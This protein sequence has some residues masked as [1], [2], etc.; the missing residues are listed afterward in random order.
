[1]NRLRVAIVGLGTVGQGVVDLL[2]RHAA[3]YERR[4]GRGIDVVAALVRDVARPREVPLPPGVLV[5]SNVD[6]FFGVPAD[7]VVEVAGGVDAARAIIERA[8]SN[9]RDVVTANKALVAAHGP[10]LFERAEKHRRRLAFEAAVAGGVPVIQ[11]VTTALGANEVRSFAG[12]LNGTCNFILTAMAAGGTYNEALAE[13]QRRGFAEADPTLD[14]S[15]RDSVEKLAILASLAFG[16]P[17][18]PD[19]ITCEGITKLTAEDVRDA[20]KRGLALKL[21]ALGTRTDRGLELWNGPTLIPADNPLA[22]VNGSDMG[23]L[24]HAD[25]VKRLF[26]AGDGAGR[27]PTASAVVGDILDVARTMGARPDG[28][29]NVW[30]VGAPAP[31]LAPLMETIDTGKRGT[32]I[33]TLHA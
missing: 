25:A 12:I 29:L 14:V 17:V 10:S 11:T 7:I 27:F 32:L 30:P 8:L 22:R 4:C 6:E 5:T 18:S 31:T 21:L 23:L 33:R 19:R 24:V 26:I 16:G 28:P 3:L 13:A 20:A 2:R 1:M 9:G 15:G